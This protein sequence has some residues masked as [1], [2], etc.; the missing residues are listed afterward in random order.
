[1]KCPKCG[2]DGVSRVMDSYEGHGEKTGLVIRR[3]KCTICGQWYMTEERVTLKY[4]R[5]DYPLHPR[6]PDRGKTT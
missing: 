6:R 2:R 3:R 4:T 1:M 5:R